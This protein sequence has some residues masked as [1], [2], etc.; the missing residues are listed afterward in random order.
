MIDD[1]LKYVYCS[2][3]PEVF[4]EL[5]VAIYEQAIDD[6]TK[7][8]ETLSRLLHKKREHLTKDNLY[9]IIEAKRLMHDVDIFLGKHLYNISEDCCK[10]IYK[11]L[12]SYLDNRFMV[13]DYVYGKGTIWK[14]Y[15]ER[16]SGKQPRKLEVKST[17][18]HN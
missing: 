5:V 6:Y 2:S 7:S 9:K 16:L 18:S 12:H 14:D 8:I 13:V 15:Q 17:R 11:K 10:A 3:N 1:E 4:S